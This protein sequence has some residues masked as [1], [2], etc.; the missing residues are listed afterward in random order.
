M[1]E[2]KVAGFPFWSS[3]MYGSRKAAEVKLSKGP[4]SLPFISSAGASLK[5][6]FVATQ[7]SSWFAELFA[8]DQL[9]GGHVIMLG[10]SPANERAAMEALHA[11]PGG[12]QV[13]GGIT[14][15][16]APAF[17]DAGASHVIVTSYV[18]R[19][20]R[21]DQDRLD[22]LVRAR[23]RV[24]V[25]VWG[26]VP[27]PDPGWGEMNRPG[28]RPACQAL[29]SSVCPPPNPTQQSINRAG[30]GGGPGAAGA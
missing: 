6:N 14:A 26:K 30:Q 12:L 4:P 16:N 19:E 13:G 18:F 10:P 5:T 27:V 17:L 2:M 21:L 8:K 1:S 25:C 9:Q 28:L 15:D 23:A 22:K 20:G 29:T 24:C 11:F 7:P 3:F